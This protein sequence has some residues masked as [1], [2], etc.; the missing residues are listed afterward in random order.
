MKKI[1][2]IMTMLLISLGSAKAI[3]QET[4][5]EKRKQAERDYDFEKC[6]ASIKCEHDGEYIPELEKTLTKDEIDLIRLCRYN[7]VL[8]CL[9]PKEPDEDLGC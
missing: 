5:E 2:M 7:R 9:D 6:I 8:T 3:C 4:D 1:L